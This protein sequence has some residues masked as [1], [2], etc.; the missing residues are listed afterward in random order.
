MRDDSEYLWTKRHDV[1]Y[2]VELSALY[3]QKRER[4]FD[5]CDKVGKAVAVIG[6]TWSLS[7]LGGDDILMIVAAAITL[8]STLSLVFGLSDHSRR[9]AGLASD[10]RQLEAAIQGRGERDFT[11]ADISA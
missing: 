5:V 11:E 10:F 3:H 8:A 9:H 7:R 1:L 4:F 6:G 2:R